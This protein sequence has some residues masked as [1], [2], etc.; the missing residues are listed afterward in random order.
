MKMDS[1]T[2]LRALAWEA[3]RRGMRYGDLSAKLASGEVDEI[4]ERYRKYIRKE[5]ERKGR[6]KRERSTEER[7]GS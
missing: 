4:V 6:K 3:K 2:T 1:M 7:G 5:K